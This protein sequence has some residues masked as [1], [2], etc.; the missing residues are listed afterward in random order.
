MNLKSIPQEWQQVLKDCR[1]RET[2]LVFSDWLEEQGSPLVAGMRWL[3]ERGK[4]PRK[5]GEKVSFLRNNSNPPIVTWRKSGK[6]HWH[7]GFQVQAESQSCL[8]KEVYTRLR[9]TMLLVEN[10]EEPMFVV[11]GFSSVLT[12]YLAAARAI[13]KLSKDKNLQQ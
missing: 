5:A 3:A 11:W 4:F 6:Y 2:W 8:P 13:R 12:A 9:A 10:R 1:D 7:Y